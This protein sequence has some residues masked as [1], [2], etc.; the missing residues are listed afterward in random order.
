MR[1]TTATAADTGTTKKRSF[2]PG[3]DAHVARIRRY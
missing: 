1:R 2:L 3:R